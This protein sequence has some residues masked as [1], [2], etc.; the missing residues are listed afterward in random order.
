MKRIEVREATRGAIDVIVAHNVAMAWES[1]GFA[2]DEELVRA[3]VSGMF[4]DPLRG[5]YLLAERDGE[6]LG[7]T[8]ITF[9]WSDWRAAYFWWIQSVYVRPKARRQGVYGALYE[10]LKAEVSSRPDVCGLRLYVHDENASAR[11]TYAAL[12]MPE[13]HYVMHEVELSR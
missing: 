5:F 12:G 10:H 3:G 8:M 4:D 7:Q 2:L 9:E 11:S 6:L 1:E 13:S